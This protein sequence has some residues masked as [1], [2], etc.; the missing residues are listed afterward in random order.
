MITTATTHN[1][2]HVC[3][4]SVA[5]H[6][7]PNNNVRVTYAKMMMAAIDPTPKHSSSRIEALTASNTNHTNLPLPPPSHLTRTTY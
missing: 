4:N 3:V 1:L 7:E 2:N 5:L 6:Y